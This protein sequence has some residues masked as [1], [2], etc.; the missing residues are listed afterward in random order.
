MAKKK[1]T[2]ISPTQA[3]DLELKELA[4]HPSKKFLVDIEGKKRA[5]ARA[6]EIAKAEAKKAPAATVTATTQS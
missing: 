6:A 5:K 1:T 4:W 2:N 3:R